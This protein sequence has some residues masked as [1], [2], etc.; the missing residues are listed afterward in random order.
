MIGRDGE[1]GGRFVNLGFGLILVSRKV[2]KMAMTA[3]VLYQK[4]DDY[5]SIF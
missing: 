3:E 5:S 4:K 1:E 2:R